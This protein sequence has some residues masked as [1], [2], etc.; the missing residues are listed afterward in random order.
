MT[1]LKSLL[2]LLVVQNFGFFV[3]LAPCQRSYI[4][5]LRVYMRL[6]ESWLVPLG[7]FRTEA[8]SPSSLSLGMGTWGLP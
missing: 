7:R 5:L 4:M 6:Y 2:Y 3:Q 1:A 8:L